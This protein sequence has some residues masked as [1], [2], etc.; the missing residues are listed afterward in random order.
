MKKALDALAEMYD[1]RNSCEVSEAILSLSTCCNLGL[2]RE[3]AS[4][5]EELAGRGIYDACLKS[6]DQGLKS[7]DQG[8]KTNE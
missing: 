6:L 7:L 2:A 5:L 3:A 4:L 8:E 1:E